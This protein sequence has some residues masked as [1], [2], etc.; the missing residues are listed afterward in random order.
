[1][2]L[3]ILDY[4]FR[5]LA[6]SYLDRHDLSQVT[7]ED[8]RA[9]AVQKDSECAPEV[10]KPVVES[11]QESNVVALEKTKMVSAAPKI[12]AKTNGNGNG[13]GGGN[14]T[15]MQKN[16]NVAVRLAQPKISAFEMARLKGY[17]GDPCNECGQMT[18]VR[19]GTC[20]KC[21][22]CGATSGCS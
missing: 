16:T 17:E 21:Q 20:L 22:S 9:D 14:G 18:L 10:S 11:T 7:P 19:N 6:I 13:N 8:L 2:L 12:E 15:S 5:D 3:S 1:M 4:I